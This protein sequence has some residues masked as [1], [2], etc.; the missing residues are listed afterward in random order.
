MLY[1]PTKIAGQV[2]DL[3]SGTTNSAGKSFFLISD[4]FLASLLGYYFARRAS[5]G[6]SAG[7]VQGFLK[8]G[9]SKP[10]Q[11]QAQKFPLLLK[12]GINK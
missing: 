10:P 8:T 2:R 9:T 5:E 4:V 12:T 3:Q 11:Q 7:L 1:S 6:A